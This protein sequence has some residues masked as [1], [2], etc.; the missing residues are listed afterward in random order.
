M[1]LG[2]YLA[3]HTDI[4]HYNTERKREFDET[5]QVPEM[6]M[7]E[8]ADVFR[9][10]NLSENELKP[11]VN[12]F[13]KDKKRWVNFMMHFELGLEEPDPKRA[14]QSALTIAI[15]YIIGGMIPL[16]PYMLLP[17]IKTALLVSV[18]VT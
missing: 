10:Y 11:I 15:S 12:A 14:T 5:E 8:M 16:S 2:D 6:E 17:D 1:G 3:A 18:C 4:E 7:E 13:S 9:D